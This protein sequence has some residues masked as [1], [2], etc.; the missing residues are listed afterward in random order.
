MGRREVALERHHVEDDAER[1]RAHPSSAAAASLSWSLVVLPCRT[2]SSTP[3]TW[4]ASPRE[5]ATGSS[6][7]ASTRT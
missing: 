1:R 7:A 2:D 4:A 6:G 3:S 5:S